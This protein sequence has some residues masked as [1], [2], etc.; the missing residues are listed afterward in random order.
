[1]KKEPYV[2]NYLDD[3][4][5]ELIETLESDDYK[6]GESLLTPE[7][8][9]QMQEAAR[10]TLNEASEKISIRIPRTDLARVKAKAFRDGIPYQTLIKSIIH[11]AVRR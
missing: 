3:E 10:N 1:M 8:L 11:Q 6:P 9:A 4:E 7:L 5:R 2:E